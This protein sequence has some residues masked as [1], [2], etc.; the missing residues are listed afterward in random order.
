MTSLAFEDRR[1]TPTLVKDTSHSAEIAEM[2]MSL[3]EGRVP[4]SRNEP[5]FLVQL[6]VSGHCVVVLE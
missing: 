2:L 1:R 6:S 4:S 5:T 3:D